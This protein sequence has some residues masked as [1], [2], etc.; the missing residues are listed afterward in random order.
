ML[1]AELARADWVSEPSGRWLQSLP[2]HESFDGGEDDTGIGTI[3]LPTDAPLR[4]ANIRWLAY[5]GADYVSAHVEGAKTLILMRCNEDCSDQGLSGQ[6]GMVTERKHDNGSMT[7]AVS[8]NIEVTGDEPPE[9]GK[10]LFDI[11]QH[12]GE[13]ISFEAEFDLD[14][15]VS[16]LYID[17]HGGEQSS[18]GGPYKVY[19][20]WETS[21]A[22]KE[23]SWLMGYWEA[24]VGSTSESFY[25]VDELVI[26]TEY[27]GPPTGFAGSDT[28]SG[29]AGTSTTTAATAGGAA[30]A[31]GEAV[32]GAAA[33]DRG[34][35]GATSASADGAQ[36]S[37]C[38]CGTTQ[39]AAARWP[40]ALLCTAIAAAVLRARDR[41]RRRIEAAT[42]DV[43]GNARRIGFHVE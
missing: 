13:W 21:N 8:E 18:A 1:H 20:D 6:R 5:Y 23:L 43:T 24:R 28:G 19:T 10:V 38:A 22:W 17:T 33:G 34:G 31:G 14:A 26:A 30:A 35:A 11:A 40:L 37:G 36:P 12:L 41:Q 9:P 15:G 39:P 3:F 7:P 42:A 27:I 4:R 16:R 2:M 32:G 25:L 29:G